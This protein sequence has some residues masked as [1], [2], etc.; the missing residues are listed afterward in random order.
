MVTTTFLRLPRMR[1]IPKIMVSPTHRY[2]LQLELQLPS[3]QVS[4][5]QPPLKFLIKTLK[6]MVVQIWI[7]FS[8]IAWSTQPDFRQR[9]QMFKNFAFMSKALVP[10]HLMLQLRS[11]QPQRVSL[12]MINFQPYLQRHL[13]LVTLWTSLNTKKRHQQLIS[14]TSGHRIHISLSFPMLQ[15]L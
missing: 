2:F 7:L 3:N 4:N 1:V 12:D 11:S 13:N 10:L 15:L 14:S 9:N 8:S 6:T 5:H